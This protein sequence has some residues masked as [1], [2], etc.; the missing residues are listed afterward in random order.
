M[1][2]LFSIIISYLFSLVGEPRVFNAVMD[3]NSENEY[4]LPNSRERTFSFYHPGW[5]SLQVSHRGP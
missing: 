2:L 3:N 4:L 5:Y 1:I